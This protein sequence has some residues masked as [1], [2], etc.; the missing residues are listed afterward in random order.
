MLKLIRR[1]FFLPLLLVGLVLVR[2]PDALAFSHDGTTVATGGY[3]DVYLWDA[4]S[5]EQ[6]AV[7]KGHASAVV[8]V[9]FTP[10]GLTLVSAS[11]DSTV[12]FWDV[13]SRRNTTTLREFGNWVW[14]VDVSPDGNSIIAGCLGEGVRLW[15]AASL[16]E[17]DADR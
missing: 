14:S 16:E 17:I 13:A 9:E 1:N 8:G 7:L 5:Y 2:T 3:S 6:I 10:D 15:E 11:L 4:R 12:R